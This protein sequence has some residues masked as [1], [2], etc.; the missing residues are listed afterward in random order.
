MK[1]EF[2]PLCVKEKEIVDPFSFKI[3]L[4]NTEDKKMAP[5]ILEER[6][7]IEEDNGDYWNEHSFDMDSFPLSQNIQPSNSINSISN[8]NSNNNQ[9]L[10][11]AILKEVKN[12]DNIIANSQISYDDNMSVFSLSS[13]SSDISTFPSQSAKKVIPP[14]KSA[15]KTIKT[16]T[17]GNWAFLNGSSAG[18]E[19]FNAYITKELEKVQE[20]HSNEGNVFEA[21]AYRKAIGQIKKYPKKITEV[22]E[23]SKLKC[24]GVKIGEKIKEI[25][26]TGKCKK[27]NFVSNDSKN[28]IINDLCLVYGIGIKQA[29][30]FYRKGIHTIK[31]LRDI[32]TELP[33]N[34][35]KGLD[36]HDDIQI[37]IPRTEVKEI[38]EKVQTELYK[39]LPKEVIN[40]E[41]CGSYRRGKE[42][43]GDIDILI[44]RTDEGLI[45][46]IIQTLVEKLM[47]KK[48]IVDILSLGGKG[49]SKNV[50]MGI[51]I[52]SSGINRRLDI[53][54]YTK[55]EFPFAV[56]YFT[57]NAYFNRSM[58]L[59]AKKK[60][61]HL[62][63]KE[64]SYR[65]TGKKII[66]KTEEDIFKALGIEYKTPKEREI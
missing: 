22:S 31:Q 30:E 47:E 29:N 60:K 59:F 14:N 5:T 36:Y 45:D 63:D 3:L 7:F 54:V 48:V 26:L 35:Q 2:I 19:N 58:R 33:V 62:S 16:F 24:V 9:E 34:I 41:V 40:A 55:E 65:N 64:L 66:C 37:K 6:S 56:L 53:K 57:G 50:F 32:Y 49:E 8:D 23:I 42:L 51:C 4:D 52:G 61:L 12:D 44:T 28:K 17:K 25:I 38:F 43:C 10:F 13:Q 20:Y 39:I 11:D 18:H 27:S 15:P 21:L 1:H 46:G